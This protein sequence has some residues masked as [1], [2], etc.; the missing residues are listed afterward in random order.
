MQIYLPDTNVL[1]DFGRNATVEKKLYSLASQGSTFVL[2]PPSITELVRGVVRT[3]SKYFASDQRV[4]KW[5]QSQK[6]PVLELPLPFVG[7]I[8]GTP[9]RKGV[10]VPQHYIDLIDVMANS[11]DFDDFLQRKNET[12]WH[13][14]DKTVQI[15]NDVLDEQFAALVKLASEP[16]PVDVAL[17]WVERTFPDSSSRPDPAT[18]RDKFSAAVEYIEC[19]LQ[20]IR[21][22]KGAA[23]LRKN[24]AGFFVDSQFFYY[25]AD[26]N[27]NFLTK[28]KFT[29][30][31][32][33]SPQ[34]TRI[35]PLDSVSLTS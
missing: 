33:S 25:L 31:I 34:R 30:E 24:D 8:L 3:G 9:V 15:H 6:Y 21:N 2:A 12:V 7:G 13:D 16:K 28:E 29:S 27:I 22:S 1:I 11:N 5:L 17:R 18:F 32:R 10:V 4:F 23:N 20:K 19:T 14:I 26:H 35:V